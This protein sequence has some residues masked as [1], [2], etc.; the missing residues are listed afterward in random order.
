MLSTCTPQSRFTS[1]FPV[2]LIRQP[3]DLAGRAWTRFQTRMSVSLSGY[4][5]LPG[6]KL[7]RP[8]GPWLCVDTVYVF[9]VRTQTE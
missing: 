7:R 8:Q 2:P 4:K 9:C 3:A 6:I 1:P 5:M